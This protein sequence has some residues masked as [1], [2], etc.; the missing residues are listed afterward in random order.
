[1]EQIFNRLRLKKD[2]YALV[3]SAPKWYLDE[4]KKYCDNVDTSAKGKYDFVQ[5]FETE[6][7]KAEQ[8]TRN[9]VSLLND[10]A[11]L[12]VCYPKGSSKNYKS[13]INRNKIWGLFADYEFEP[14]SQVSIDDDWSAIRFRHIDK[15]KTLTRKTAATEKGKQRI[16]GKD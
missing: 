5:T 4:I 11:L 8:S 10:D 6:L 1:M 14:V 16:E 13:D 7:S 9:L 15:I 3:Q 12:W 2:I